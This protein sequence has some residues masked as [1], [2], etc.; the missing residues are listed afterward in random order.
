MR[1]QLSISDSFCGVSSRG[2]SSLGRLV[3]GAS[4]AVAMLQCLVPVLARAE[5]SDELNADELARIQGGEQVTITEEVDGSVW[6]RITVYHKASGTPEEYMA[7]FW[8]FNRHKDYFDGMKNSAVSRVLQPSELLV[9]YTMHFPVVM[10]ISMP[11]ENYTA[12]DVLST[13]DGGRSYR[14]AWTKDRADTIKDVSGS[15]R[16]E[17]YEGGTLVAYQSLIVPPK[18]AL[19]RLLVKV[20]IARVQQAQ[21]ALINRLPWLKRN[22]PQLLAEELATLRQALSK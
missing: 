6:P 2:T 17:P 5:I 13:Y 3:A 18:P 8:D 9:D 15:L 21:V 11:D 16:T 12:H 22:S 19:A 10:G 20:A 1:I 14:C 4:A 7:V